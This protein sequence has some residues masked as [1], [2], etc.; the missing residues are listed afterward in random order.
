MENKKQIRMLYVHSFEWKNKD[1]QKRAGKHPE[2]GRIY[3][4]VDNDGVLNILF[5]DKDVELNGIQLDEYKI[6]HFLFSCDFEEVTEENM[7]NFNIESEDFIKIHEWTEK[8]HGDLE[9]DKVLEGDNE[10]RAFAQIPDLA[11]SYTKLKKAD[12]LLASSIK[13]VIA[14]IAYMHSNDTPAL[15]FKTDLMCTTA[16]TGRGA[17]VALTL[18]RLEKYM[19]SIMDFPPYLVQAVYYMLL[20]IARITDKNTN[21]D[22]KGGQ[23]NIPTA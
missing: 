7:T 11:D 16:E 1:L 3:R 2:V 14:S 17:N 13:F 20:E 5:E 18:D 21:G 19:N 6:D 4:A 12:P 22:T 23:G 8:D 9:F 10:N 15:K